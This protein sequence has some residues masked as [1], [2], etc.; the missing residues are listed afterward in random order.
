[1][2]IDVFYFELRRIADLP[3]DRFNG[4]LAS[5]ISFAE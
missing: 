1:M 4:A 5:E 2:V 3:F